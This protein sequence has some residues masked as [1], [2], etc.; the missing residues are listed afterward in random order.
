MSRVPFVSVAVTALV[1]GALALIRPNTPCVSPS[2]PAAQSR[3]FGSRPLAPSRKASPRSP[4]SQRGRHVE[5]G[6][7]GGRVRGGEVAGERRLLERVVQDVDL[8]V[9]EVG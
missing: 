7:P 9:V 6:V 3:G 4:P 1:P 5:R 8:G 2:G